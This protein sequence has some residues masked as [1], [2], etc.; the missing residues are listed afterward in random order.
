MSLDY[1]IGKIPFP[2]R[3]ERITDPEYIASIKSGNAPRD[4]YELEEDNK[5]G[6]EPGVWMMT[7]AMNALIWLT[8]SVGMNQITEKNWKTF[9]TRTRLMELTHG[10]FRNRRDPETG[11]SEPVYFT[12]EE[13]KAHIGLG[14]NVSPETDARWRKRFMDN[15]TRDSER[16]CAQ[17]E[18]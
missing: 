15:F 11:K 6:V 16:K 2:A 10:A 9:F 13:V 8:M 17:T 12:P 3:A 1:T 5:H 4:W 7:P 14:T 18:D